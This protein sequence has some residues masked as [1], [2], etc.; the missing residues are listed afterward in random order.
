MSTK[1]DLLHLLTENLGTYMSGQALAD[2]LGIS[3][4]AVNKAATALRQAG[5]HIQSR[6]RVGYR[7]A[8]K[9]EFLSREQVEE[10]LTKPCRVIV[11]DSVDSTNQYAKKEDLSKGPVLVV[12]DRQTAGRGRLGRTFASPSG[13]GV[14]FSLAFRPKF[15]LAK[16]LFITMAAAIATSRAI[17][18]VTQE[19]PKIKWVND[20]FLQGKKIC[21]ILTEAQTNFESGE[22]E[23]IIIGIG[24]NCF[25]GSFPEEISAIAGS[26]SQEPGSFSRGYLA[27]RVADHLLS[28]VETFQ[29]RSFLAEYRRRCFILGKPITVRAIATGDET[30]AKALD[31]DDNGGLVVEYTSGLHMHEIHTLTS[32]EVTL[33]VE[34]Y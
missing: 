22:I 34:D 29:D 28:L 21:G 23:G 32:G 30:P 14:Y 18:E 24:I 5:Y 11:L 1:T 6:T 7:L 15:D 9:Q 4:A 10:G 2:E 31:I 13:T 8:E 16:S 17:E 27:G 33:R 20:L 3:R 19:S 26:V 12:A 25:P